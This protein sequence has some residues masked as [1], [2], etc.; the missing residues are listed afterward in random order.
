MLGKA[1]TVLLALFLA[2]S[3]NLF[4]QNP[5]LDEIRHDFY[6]T[7]L[8]YQ[9]AFPLIEKLAKIRNPNAIQLA[10]RAAT[11]AMLAKPGW[12]IFR[13]LKHLKDSKA[14]F[15]EAI[16]KDSMDLEI[17][18]LR[19]CV[20]HHIPGYLG[21]GNH[22]SEDKKIILENI[23]LFES[24]QL[25]LEISQYIVRFSRESGI[26]TKEEVSQIRNIFNI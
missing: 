7:T 8:D 22:I 3:V 11:E 9:H 15:D 25:P 19:L 17:R 13:K 2:G 1:L 20:E 18:F 4:S 10:Y 14:F 24:K 6:L 23:G 16:L 5:V 26:Y 21:Y 12:N